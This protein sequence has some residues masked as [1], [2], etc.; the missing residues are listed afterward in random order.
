MV[1]LQVAELPQAS[2]AVQVRLILAAVGQLPASVSSANVTL[3]FWSQSSAKVGVPKAGGAG[4]WMV[5]S[6]GQEAT[7]GAVWF[8]SVMVWLHEDEL[9]QASVADQVRRTLLTAGQLAASVS[10]ENVTVGLESHASVKTGVPNAGCAGHWMVSSAGQSAT[11]GAVWSSAVMVWRSEERRVGKEGGC[12]WWGRL[13][14][15]QG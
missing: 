5:S 7:S 14:K 9:P 8:S 6:A 15:R 10:S 2:V 11:T 3:R 12:G 13:C 4:H 1:W